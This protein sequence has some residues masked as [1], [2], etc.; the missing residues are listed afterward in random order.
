MRLRQIALVARELTPV[1]DDLC[2]VLDLEVGFR[3]P[4]IASFGLHNAVLPIGD[5]FLEVVSPETEGTSAG[6]LLERRA[7]DG[8]YMVIVQTEDLAKAR[9]RLERIG[10]RIVW[11]V[12]LEDAASIHLHPRDV[13]GAILSFD[14][15]QPREAWRWAGPDWRAHV[16]THAVDQIVGAEIEAH[17]PERMTARWAEAMDRS[18]EGARI[19]LDGGE[20]RFVAATPERGEGVSGLD[21]RAT[22]ASRVL[23]RARERGLESD[24]DCIEICGTR[25]R[26]VS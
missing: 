2:A 3:D 5:T 12:D 17:D 13:G 1:V 7:G 9:E 21:L 22:D 16:R 6:R 26:L 18:A 14:A 4:G 19:R 10:V 8:G 23:A 24:R 25:I 15:M 20:L 11:Q